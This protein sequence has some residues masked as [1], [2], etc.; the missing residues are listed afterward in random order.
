VHWQQLEVTLEAEILPKAE[1]LLRLAGAEAISL[2][3]AGETEL[4]EPAPGTAP[5]WPSVVLSALFPPGTD[6]GGAPATLVEALGSGITVAIRTLHDDDWQSARHAPPRRRRIGPRLS[7]AAAGQA[8]SE[9]TG[10]VVRL[11]F[12]LAF[13]TG[14]HPTTALC[15]EWLEAHLGAGEEVLDYGCGSGILAIAAL[16]LGARAA[17]AVDTEPQALRASHANAELNGVE[18]RLWIGSPESLPALKADVLLANILAGTLQDLMPRFQECVV[19]GGRLVLSGILERQSPG[20]QRAF[21]G[22]CGP[23]TETCR[24]GWVRL[25]APRL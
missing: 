15:L 17:W 2:A 11:H 22:C 16:K 7:I 20:V 6:L 3:G 10:A 25:S 19:A 12:G 18:D 1:A 4:Y 24:D 14:G 13:G 9:V 23:F 21:G 5:L 8:E